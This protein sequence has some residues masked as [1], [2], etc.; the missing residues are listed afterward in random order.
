MTEG[1]FDEELVRKLI[2]NKLGNSR[3]QVISAHGKSSA[4]SLARTL[5]GIKKSPVALVIDADEHDSIK[6]QEGRTYIE[7]LLGSAAPRDMWELVLFV[8]ALEIIFFKTPNWFQSLGLPP[9]STLQRERAEHSPRRV[10]EELLRSNLKSSRQDPRRWLIEKMS[11]ASIELL[12]AT[13]PLATLG[14]FIE[15]KKDISIG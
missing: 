13:E 5:A 6:I 1:L 8:P 10:L 15:R 3:V 12:W 4:Q 14:A 2:A 7:S 11:S 9:P